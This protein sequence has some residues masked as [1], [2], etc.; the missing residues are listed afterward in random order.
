MIKVFCTAVILLVIWIE[1]LHCANHN[2]QS[3]FGDT[4][5][6]CDLQG[7]LFLGNS[8]NQKIAT[9]QNLEV[10]KSLKS[11]QQQGAK[12]LYIEENKADCMFWQN[13]I[14]ANKLPLE[15]NFNLSNEIF[16]GF[17]SSLPSCRLGV[18]L[19][20]GQPLGEVLG[21]VINQLSVWSQLKPKKVLFYT[22]DKQHGHILS[23][24]VNR[25]GIPVEVKFVKAEISLKQNFKSIDSGKSKPIETKTTEKQKNVKQPKVL[26]THDNKKEEKAKEPTKPID[27]IILDE[28]KFEAV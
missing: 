24:I 1:K 4:L 27:L 14:K 25:M 5:V 21:I 7:T 12:I 16:Y 23:V 11:H 26:V 17:E 8:R 2:D 28:S 9:I 15:T 6:I 22:S 3:S 10:A 18:V 13:S 20:Q 19:C